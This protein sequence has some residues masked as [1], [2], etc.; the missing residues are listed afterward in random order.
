MYMN[1]KYIN[2]YSKKKHTKK[3]R[4]KP[5][6][7]FCSARFVRHCSGV[8]HD[9]REDGDDV[10]VEPERGGGA[11]VSE[12]ERERERVCA[13][14]CSITLVSAVRSPA[15]TRPAEQKETKA[16]N[17]PLDVTLTFFWT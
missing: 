10:N 14:C 11:G 7:E 8:N 17:S 15:A 2:I 1:T 3:K 16:E 12:R 5:A 6:R 4:N 13:G 9:E